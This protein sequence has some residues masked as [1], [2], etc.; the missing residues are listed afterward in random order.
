MRF[1]VWM[2]CIKNSSPVYLLTIFISVYTVAPST[3]NVTLAQKVLRAVMHEIIFFYL[4]ISCGMCKSNRSDAWLELNVLPIMRHWKMPC[5]T[6]SNSTT[7]FQPI[8]LS[9]LWLCTLRN[10]FSKYTANWTKIT[11]GGK[12]SKLSCLRLL[13]QLVFFPFFLSNP[14]YIQS[15]LLS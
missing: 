6:D 8:I 2:Y 15:L 9:V 3:W 1:A 14:Q 5:K 10:V 4:H 13:G 7:I 12:T 11:R